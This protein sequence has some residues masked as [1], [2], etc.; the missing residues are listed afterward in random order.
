MTLI[1]KAH[2]TIEFIGDSITDCGRREPTHQPLGAGYVRKI[3]DLLQAGYPELNLSVVNKGISGDRVPDLQARWQDDAIALNPDWLF[4]YIGINDVWRFFE[5]ER[6]EAIPLADF[7]RTYRQ[8]LMD[9]LGKTQS[10]VRLISP[11]LAERNQDD[12]FRKKLSDYQVV[13]DSL[14]EE[15]DLYVNHLQ[16]AFDWAMLSQPA[17]Y[18]TADRVH[19]TEVGHTL[20]TLTILRACG[21]TL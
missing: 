12:P 4:I 6:S 15:F 19:P 2:Q 7:E 16:P 11:Y 17:D 8:I 9:T 3:H 1:F 13:V 14:G 5:F 10:E 18:W 21:F 20:I